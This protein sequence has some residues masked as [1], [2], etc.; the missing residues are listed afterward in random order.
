MDAESEISENIPLQKL[1][2]KGDQLVKLEKS[3]SSMRE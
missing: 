1:I 3:S 2:A